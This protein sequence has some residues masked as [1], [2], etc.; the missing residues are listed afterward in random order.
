VLG[1]PTQATL[2]QAL[3]YYAQNCSIAKKG[4]A[5]EL[6]RINQYLEATELP[7]LKAYENE[8]GGIDIRPLDRSSLRPEFEAYVRKRRGEREG[9]FA[10]KHRL[11]Q[12]K[13]SRISPA[14]ILAFRAQMLKAVDSRNKVSRLPNQN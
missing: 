1:G 14:D 13:C 6:T 7:L 2:A 10:F 3:D 5:Q 8:D 9:T 11:A 4:V 12:M